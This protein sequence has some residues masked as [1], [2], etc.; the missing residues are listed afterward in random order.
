V[1]IFALDSTFPRRPPGPAA[2]RG[3]RLRAVLLAA[4]RA[5]WAGATWRATAHV[6]VGGVL[7]V[8]SMS[9]VLALLVA[10]AGLAV[11]IV[12]PAVALVALLAC[13]QGFTALQ[14]SR[15]TAFLGED[16]AEGLPGGAGWPRRAQAEDGAQR[17]WLARAW[18]AAWAPA[19]WRQ[20]S[21]HL[22]AGL[23]GMV[24]FA[25]VA[26]AWCL[27]LVLSTV[28]LDGW[29]LPTYGPFGVDLQNPLVLAAVA[30]LAA[31]ALLTAPWIA[32]AAAAVDLAAARALLGPT[33]MEER[34]E[35]TQWVTGLA[36]SRVAMV[37]AAD[38]ERRRIE[39]DLHD[40]T[41][42]R[43]VALAMNLGIA[44]ASL[45]D[46]LDMPDLPGLP[47]SARA[48]VAALAEAHEDAKQAL[49]E[50]RGFV[51]GL[52]PAVLND[53]GLDAALSGLAARSPVPVR[54]QVDLPRRP[55]PI[56]EAVAYFVTSEA[57]TNVAKHA[58]ASRVEVTVR[59][60]GGGQHE[61]RLSLA[62]IDDGC[63]GATPEGGTGLRGLAHR[64]ASVDGTLDISSPL[65]GPTCVRAELPCAL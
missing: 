8:V 35:L 32:R 13:V 59:Q 55:S 28:P 54:L 33:R 27:A 3:H 34:A 58:H 12:V 51:R 60:H 7:G 64:I 24:G 23:V 41:Q 57:L 10:G 2:G 63:G 47:G 53:R 40:G 14:R 29:G 6:L 36:Q 5:T 4:I 37:E 56:T 44:R 19:T 22:L 11:T 45:P 31:A 52:H 1:S 62:I 61:G 21:Y 42:Q 17:R 65:G 50:L 43:L 18:T 9:V 39:R 49:A 30:A 25:A 20:I 26:G 48:V 46:L 16:P 15:F 38:A